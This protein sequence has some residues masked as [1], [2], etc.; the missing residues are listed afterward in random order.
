M[1][2]DNVLKFPEGVN[3]D[4]MSKEDLDILA[5]ALN[6]AKPEEVKNMEESFKKVDSENN[7]TME[8]EI[9]HIST[10]STGKI[11]PIVSEEESNNDDLYKNNESLS[12]EEVNDGGLE[13]K[14]EDVAKESIKGFF[15]AV[16]DEGEEN[17]NELKSSLSDEDALTLLQSIQEYQRGVKKNYYTSLPDKMKVAINNM[18]IAS[19]GT[20]TAS[21]RN[22][23]AKML[24]DQF[25]SEIN[26]NQEYIDLET[27]MKN[28]LELPSIPD[29]YSD[30]IKEMMETKTLEM[31]DRIEEESPEKA[32]LLR[33][34]S[35]AFTS[36]YTYDKMLDC[37]KNNRKARNHISKDRSKYNKF[38][39]DFNYESENS[40]FKINDIFMAGDVLI[41]ML[42]EGEP[43]S[44]YSE[45]NVIDFIILLC[46]TCESMSRTDI[47]DCAFIYHVV[48]N[49]VMLDYRAKAVTDFSNTIISNI[50]NMMNEIAI[51]EEEHERMI[52]N[53]KSKSKKGNNSK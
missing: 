18:V 30:Y 16:F 19:G 41:R 17:K 3:N 10:D 49:I 9:G 48:K 33:K 40:K 25:I 22:A 53:V 31:A 6:E 21:N 7:T 44:E 34:V 27:T 1:S 51:A 38:C 23:A 12:A 20:P 28:T 47:V 36:S 32:E 50:K 8:E 15:G 24:L 13:I 35:A 42:E 46:K 11:V 45:N 5:D 2:N 37:L 4:A 39:K 52:Q 26:M 43:L 29:I 14:N